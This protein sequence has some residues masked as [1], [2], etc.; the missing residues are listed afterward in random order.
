MKVL[1][2]CLA[3]GLGGFLG[4]I[5][6]FGVGVAVGRWFTGRFPLGTFII[7]ITGCLLLGWFMTISGERLPLSDTMKLAIATGFI[8]AYTT[9]S[10]FIYESSRLVD[11][12]AWFEAAA[13]LLLSLAVGL[14]AVRLGIML[15]RRA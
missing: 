5:S 3:V 9:F 4:A 2:Q 8:G 6:R 10:T 12:G 11:D 13:N 15:A 1:I 14:I 7:N